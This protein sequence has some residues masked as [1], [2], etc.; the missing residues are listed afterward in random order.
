[1]SSSFSY[2]TPVSP[3]CSP[4]QKKFDVERKYNERMTRIKRL[5]QECQY[6]RKLLE[7]SFKEAL[8]HEQKQSDSIKSGEANNKQQSPDN[9]EIDTNNENDE[10]END[11]IE[12]DE[13]EKGKDIDNEK[14]NNENEDNENDDNKNEDSA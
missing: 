14:D 10:K 8:E 13:I 6:R 7:N 5:N 1:M 3:I 12:N 4:L 2:S 9:T 11:E